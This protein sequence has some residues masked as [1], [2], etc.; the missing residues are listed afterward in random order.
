MLLS[1]KKAIERGWTV[2]FMPPSGERNIKSM[3]A[4][5]SLAKK[6]QPSVFVM[7]DVDHEHREHDPYT[8]RQILSNLDGIISKGSRMV[9]LMSTNF[10][11]KI[12]GGLLR[13]GRTDEI[14]SFGPLGFAGLCELVQRCVGSGKLDPAID[15]S[16]VYDASREYTPAFVKEMATSAA[17]QAVSADVK[18]VTQEMLIDAAR[19]LRFQFDETEKARSTGQYL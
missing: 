9:V 13:P 1:A 10:K 18:I 16:E 17:L 2:V 19:N 15:W 6:Y 3:E 4:G 11:E 14:V 5:L 7:E 8:F 12:K